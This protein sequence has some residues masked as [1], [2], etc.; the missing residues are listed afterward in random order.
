[1]HS[2]PFKL[3]CV[4][5]TNLQTIS[6]FKLQR[7]NF[8]F[9]RVEIPVGTYILQLP[10]D[11]IELDFFFFFHLDNIF[12]FPPSCFSLHIG[13][14]RPFG[15]SKSP[16]TRNHDRF[17]HSHYRAWRTYHVTTSL[18]KTLV[19]VPPF[20]SPPYSH[21][22]ALSY[23]FGG[24]RAWLFNT[25]MMSSALSINLLT[26][27]R[28]CIDRTYIELGRTRYLFSPSHAIGIGHCYVCWKQ[29]SSLHTL[30]F[31]R[32]SS[33]VRDMSPCILQDPASIHS[34]IGMY[35]QL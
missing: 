8:D 24:L 28:V 35:K 16:R 26:Y 10:P 25:T 15:T 6:D 23:F 2:R 14:G 19:L 29:C 11:P 27:D 22:H 5:N 31:V 32:W 21:V 7:F 34:E 33:Q 13:A 3:H 18:A 4:T 17:W 12:C 30:I 20:T 1:M 9:H